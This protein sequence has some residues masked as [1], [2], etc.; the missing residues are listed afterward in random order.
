[1]GIPES[2]LGQGRYPGIEVDYRRSRRLDTHLDRVV[3]IDP[4]E[5]APAEQAAETEPG[6]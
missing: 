2:R 3:S 4:V 6:S 1:M 5:P